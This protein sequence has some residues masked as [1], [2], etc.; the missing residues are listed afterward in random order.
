MA[1]LELANELPS[2]YYMRIKEDKYSLKICLETERLKEIIG[3]GKISWDLTN[4]D[5]KSVYCL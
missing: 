5:R 4:I 2:F 3:A 1:Q